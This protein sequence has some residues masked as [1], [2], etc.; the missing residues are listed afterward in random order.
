[1]ITP[2]A[3]RVQGDIML[4]ATVLNSHKTWTMLCKCDPAS[5]WE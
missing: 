2:V 1:M 3:F 5:P 4:L